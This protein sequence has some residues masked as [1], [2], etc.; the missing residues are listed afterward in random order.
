MYTNW[1]VENFDAAA[2]QGELAIGLDFGFTNDIS[3]L[4]A[5]IITSD[6]I[7]VFKTW[8]DT[9]KTN[10]D[11]AHIITGLGFAKSTIIADAAEPKSIEELRRKGI[12]RIN[13]CTKGKDSIIHGIQAVQQY[14]LIV[15][16]NCEGIIT[17]L[18]N[19]AWK[20][21]KATNEY[22]N[23]PIDDFNHYLDALRYSLQV[24]NKKPKLQSLNKEAAFGL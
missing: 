17:E 20:K 3:A 15:S 6:K 1:K 5:S 11:L 9:G 13:A 19:Y 18:E 21:D 23:E 14:E 22:T 4:V 10:D 12:K 16:P 8:G 2:I 24:I 7:Y